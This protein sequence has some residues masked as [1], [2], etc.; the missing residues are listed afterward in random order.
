[1]EANSCSVLRYFDKDRSII[2]R[3]ADMVDAFRL[4]GNLRKAGQ[5]HRTADAMGSVSINLS[6]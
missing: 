3:T 4:T 5:P 2:H 6:D 1:M